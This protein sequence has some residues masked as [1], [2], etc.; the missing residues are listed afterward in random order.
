MEGPRG[1]HTRT[2]K[3]CGVSH[4]QGASAVIAIEGPDLEAGL[5][6]KMATPPRKIVGDVHVPSAGWSVRAV[7]KQFTNL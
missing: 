5:A 3:D 1:P 4:L 6:P 2:I 7:S